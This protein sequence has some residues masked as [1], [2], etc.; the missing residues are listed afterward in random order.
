MAKKKYA[1]LNNPPI[2]EAI[3]QI[4]VSP[5]KNLDINDLNEI[6]KKEKQRYPDK[7]AQKTTIFE[8]ISNEDGQKSGVTNRGINGYKIKSLEDQYIAQLFPDKL[9]VSKLDPYKSWETLEHEA[10][11]LWEVYKG[12]T[13]PGQIT[14]I[15][16]RYINHFNLPENMN[17][18]E[19]YL[20]SCPNIP[21]DLPQGF[22][23]FY[24]NIRLPDT[25]I[26]AVANIQ[27]IFEGVKIEDENTRTPIVLDIDVYKNINIPIESDR[28]WEEFMHLHDYKN[29][30]FFNS[31]T[32]KCLELFK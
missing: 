2:K 5:D 24:T 11:R 22:A 30:I 19:D 3:I 18:F 8:L 16:V 25:N 27:T 32:K 9:A 14:G 1:Q 23:S 4:R 15:S 20:T 31:L 7:S 12:T 21:K 13:K 6:T 29:A 17:D 26:G 10:R 28:L